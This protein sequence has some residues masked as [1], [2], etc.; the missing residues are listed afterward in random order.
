MSTR[1]LSIPARLLHRRLNR[2]G[3]VGRQLFVH[4]NSD[5]SIEIWQVDS[6]FPDSWQCLLNLP[7]ATVIYSIPAFSYD[8]PYILVFFGGV[9][10]EEDNFEILIYRLN[11]E[12]KEVKKFRLDPSRCLPANNTFDLPLETVSLRIGAKMQC[13]LFDRS[14][15]QGPIPYWRLDFDEQNDVFWFERDD[16]KAR[17]VRDADS[18]TDRLQCSRFS[19]AF[20]APGR[21]FGRLQDDGSMM[22]YNAQLEKWLQYSLENSST[23][24][25]PPTT[26]RGLRESYGRNG[27]RVGAV[28]SPL[29]FHPDSNGICIVKLVKNDHRHYF[30]RMQL[31]HSSQTFSCSPR[32]SVHLEKGAFE[33]LLSCHYSHSASRIPQFG[34]YKKFLNGNFLRKEQVKE[35]CKIVYRNLS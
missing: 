30:Y 25:L 8:L 11:Y 14:I 33:Q 32:G 26:V 7:A 34:A 21:I 19:I 35:L 10:E 6:I 2:V 3:I 22:I 13:C 16:I 23:F 31:D 1:Y 18:E 9:L 24:D 5:T 20:D 17:D 28:E 29:T 12:T 4:P 15:V 27:R